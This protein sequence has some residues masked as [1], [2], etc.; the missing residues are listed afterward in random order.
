MTIVSN[1]DHLCAIT[2]ISLTDQQEK[3][4]LNYK[5]M[6]TSVGIKT[7]GSNVEVL[8][9]CIDGLSS[10]YGYCYM[11]NQTFSDQLGFGKT[12]IAK[13]L[14]IMQASHYIYRNTFITS[15]GKIRHIVTREN[16]K[17]YWDTF[18]NR[19]CVPK[20][21]KEDFLKTY[22]TMHEA[23][24]LPPIPL[25]EPQEG[26]MISEEERIVTM[27]IIEDPE[28]EEAK[29]A[30]RTSIPRSKCE[31]AYSFSS[32][33]KGNKKESSSAKSIAPFSSS[34]SNDSK[35]KSLDTHKKIHAAK[36][37]TLTQKQIDSLL[38]RHGREKYDLIIEK[39]SKYKSDT[40]KQY[41]SDYMAILKWVEMAAANEINIA[42]QKQKAAI[43][44]IPKLQKLKEILVLKGVRGNLNWQDGQVTDSVLKKSISMS[45]E[46][47]M[48][49]VARWY[50]IDIDE[51]LK[52]EDRIQ[53]HKA[54][55]NKI[56]H[57]ALQKENLS[58][59]ADNYC[60]TV[61]IGKRVVP[62]S[63][64]SETFI[65]NLNYLIELGE[66]ND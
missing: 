48:S 34:S 57:R 40:S 58:I 7:L 45:S 49:C 46:N 10:K 64:A 26:E 43:E 32:I 65:K 4:R 39:L 54:Y 52:R 41:S 25:M 47:L 55:L 8:R 33:S 36:N 12:S 20:H 18:L 50:N 51:V 16:M 44:C 6:V 13:Y 17:R 24:P 22:L 37:V 9:A 3:Y 30:S 31:S 62:L 63:Y 21:V 35:N 61:S 2:D 60:C 66:S 28:P 29:F 5:Y 42:N 1:N 23:A 56:K 11:K 19:E 14:N 38:Q 27:E 59:T 15:R 53:M